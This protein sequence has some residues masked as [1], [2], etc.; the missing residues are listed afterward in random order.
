MLFPSVLNAHSVLSVVIN[1]L[2]YLGFI[3]RAAIN[4]LKKGQPNPFQ[5][6]KAA[7]MIVLWC[8]DTCTCVHVCIK[9][10]WLTH[11][12]RETHPLHL[13]RGSHSINWFLQCCHHHCSRVRF[14]TTEEALSIWEIPVK[15]EST[16]YCVMWWQTQA[17]ILVLH[18]LCIIVN[19]NMGG[20]GTRLCEKRYGN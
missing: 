9:S 5:E 7:V 6:H 2:F 13:K 8:T 19:V 4:N 11:G 15:H 16:L 12:P 20:L 10:I 18:Q 17:G 14:S 3:P 1:S